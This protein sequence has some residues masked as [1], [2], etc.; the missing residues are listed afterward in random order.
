MDP[1][2]HASLGAACALATARRGNR[3][4]AAL[5][6]LLAGTLPDADIFLSSKTDPLFNIE[7]H[8][9]FTHSLLFSPVIALLG[10][11]LAWLLL[12]MLRQKPLWRALLLPAWAAALSHLFCDFWTS[13]G[14]RLGWP[15]SDARAALHWISVVD[16]LLTLPLLASLGVALWTKRMLPVRI[17]LAWVACY[18]S[19]A[20]VQQ[21]RADAVL[22]AWIAQQEGGAG[23]WRGLVKPSFGNVVVWRALARTDDELRVF[24][25]RCSLGQPQII[26]GQSAPLLATVQQAATHFGLPADSRQAR[27]IRRFYHFSSDWVGLHPDDPMILAD[28]RYAALPNEVAPMWGI[29]VKPEQPAAAID[30]VP[31]A[32]LSGRPWQ[33]LWQMIAGTHPALRSPAP[34]RP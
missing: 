16:P 33:E 20:V 31:Q 10:A 34:S 8:R 6:G 24:A 5:A 13:Y 15:F 11:A 17:G 7:F 26:E 30:W 9:H 28:L 21:R 3:R 19:C 4:Q 18:L 1:I 22:R 14:M 12:K 23:R 2:T 25:V 27:D 32:E 29:R